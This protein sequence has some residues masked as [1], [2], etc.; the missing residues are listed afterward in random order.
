MLPKRARPGL[1]ALALASIGL[2]ALGGTF[3]AFTAETSNPGNV[4]S[5]ASDFVAPSV[6]RSVIARS[7][8]AAPG[9]VKQ[10]GTY[11]VYAQVIDTGNPASG[12]ATVTAN[13]SNLTAG[14]TAASLTAGSYSV[15]GTTYNYRSALQ[16]AGAIVLE[17]TQTY[18][19]SAT[20][21]DSNTAT[22]S[23]L[24]VQVDNTSPSGSDVQTA[25]G[26]GTAGRPQAGDSITF[27]FSEPIEPDSV[28]SGWDGGSTSV[29]ARL[30][31]G[32]LGSADTLR[33]YDSP[34]NDALALGTTDLGR[35]DY[36]SGLAGGEILRFGA[37]GTA[38]TMTMTGNAITVTFGTASGTG[39][40]STAGG[41]GSMIW[42]PSSAAKDRAGNAALVTPRTETG[43]ADAEF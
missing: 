5:A 28:L 7:A 24:S 14:V 34:D 31:N 6:D 4:V 10:G 23:D 22:R 8:T 18:S 30:T 12:V 36:V 20:D 1:F 37:T 40:A 35:N 3:A 2:G 39:S 27:T 38:S 17:G 9:Y 29:V 25:D 15:G 42:T 33:I 26:G 43:A 21:S 41:N 11:Y 19:V 16:T 13:L 32:L